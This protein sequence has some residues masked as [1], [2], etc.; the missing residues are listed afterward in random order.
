MKRISFISMI[1]LVMALINSISYANAQRNTIMKKTI[2]VKQESIVSIAC[3]TANGD[4]ERLKTALSTGL[5]AGLTINEI[6]EILVQLY[7]YAGFPRSLNAISTFET[8]VNERRKKGIKD[9][10]GKEPNKESFKDGKF[11]FGKDVQ[12]KLTG[13]TATGAAQQFVPIID[14][15]L[16]EHLFADIFSRDNLDY[17]SREIATVSALASIKGLDAQLRSHLKVCKNIGFTEQQLKD[18]AV[19]LSNTAGH[20]AGNTATAI[21]DDIFK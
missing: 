2:T 6:K 21:I 3:Y 9:E 19:I 20:Q 16:K 11:Q 17:Q 7:A 13:S 5:D 4:Q 18:I 10:E 1:A 8:V 14:T 15:F 12:T